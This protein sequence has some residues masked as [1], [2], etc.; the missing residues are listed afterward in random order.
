MTKLKTSEKEKVQESFLTRCRKVFLGILIIYLLLAMTVFS[1]EA[2]FVNLLGSKKHDSSFVCVYLAYLIVLEIKTN[3]ITS[4][5]GNCFADIVSPSVEP[6]AKTVSS[7]LPPRSTVS[8]KI[9]GHIRHN[10]PPDKH[11]GKSYH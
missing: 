10:S 2:G 8:P 7:I 1:L 6:I 9:V 11:G 3:T 5:T 4:I